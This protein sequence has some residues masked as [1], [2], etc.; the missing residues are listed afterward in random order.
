M[1]TRM[2]MTNI[3]RVVLGTVSAAAL[4]TVAAPMAQ[5]ARGVTPARPCSVEADAQSVT[6]DN[7]TTITF[8]NNSSEPVNIHWIN[9]S[10]ERVLY[11]TLAPSTSYTQGTYLTH[12]WVVTDALGTCIQ[13]H[14]P[15]GQ[16]SSAIIA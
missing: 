16:D 8:V 9:Y 3:R 5:A 6:G 7:S 11:T 4:M 13:A 14:M 2:T 1:F 12:P 15:R 10:G